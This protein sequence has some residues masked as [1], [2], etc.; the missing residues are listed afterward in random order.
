[1]VGVRRIRNILQVLFILAGVYLF[2]AC[3]GTDK[4]FRPKARKV[5]MRT[6]A[7]GWV[8]VPE[9]YVYDGRYRFVRGHY[10]KILSR[11]AYLRRT[12]RGY[13]SREAHAAAR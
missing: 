2:Q 6:P 1:M 10:R 3:S 5:V 12:L 4:S 13:G 11:K 8:Y 9:Y 7:A